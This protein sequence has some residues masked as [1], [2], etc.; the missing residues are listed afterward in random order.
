MVRGL[1]VQ[2][3]KLIHELWMMSRNTRTGR[4]LLLHSFNQMMLMVETKT[5]SSSEE[6]P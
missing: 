4:I 6:R 3:E 5:F 1:K 2:V